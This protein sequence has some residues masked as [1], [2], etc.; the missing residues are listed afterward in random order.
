[1]LI[2]RESYHGDYACTLGRV[3]MSG[4]DGMDSYTRHEIAP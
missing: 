3:A 2:Q 4:G 1:M